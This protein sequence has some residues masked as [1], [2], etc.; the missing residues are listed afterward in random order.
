MS[1]GMLLFDVILLFVPDEEGT[2]TSA[3][4]VLSYE[5]TLKT[6]YFYAVKDLLV[7]GW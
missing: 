3:D 2:Y 1:V 6:F 5:V 4:L 7:A